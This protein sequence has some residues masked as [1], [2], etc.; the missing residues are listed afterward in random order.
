[1]KARCNYLNDKGERQ[2][3]YGMNVRGNYL[4]KGEKLFGLLKEE[5][6]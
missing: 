4:N 6:I 5:I 3:F 1:M 2:L